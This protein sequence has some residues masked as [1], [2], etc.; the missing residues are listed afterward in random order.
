M[1]NNLEI[2]KIFEL[3]TVQSPV[4]RDISIGL[5]D[6]I[7][8]FEKYHNELLIIYYKDFLSNDLI[9]VFRGKYFKYL[10]LDNNDVILLKNLNK[11]KFDKIRWDENKE[12]FESV[13]HLEIENIIHLEIENIS[14]LPLNE[15]IFQRDNYLYIKL[16]SNCIIIT[17]VDFKIINVVNI[18]DFV[19]I[20]FQN[21]ALVDINHNIYLK[22][23]GGSTTF[24]LKHISN[25]SYDLENPIKIKHNEFI[26]RWYYHPSD[27]F[28]AVKNTYLMFYSNISKISESCNLNDLDKTELSIKIN[29]DYFYPS[30][31]KYSINH[32]GDMIFI[33]SSYGNMEYIM[34]RIDNPFRSMIKSA[35]E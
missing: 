31:S 5:N 18:I 29:D 11:I 24:I 3:K 6:R 16:S 30:T 12:E 8:V 27:F 9:E 32:N 4:K 19:N 33:I 22:Y 23:Q 13:I 10:R 28:V 15:F 21:L 20:R 14:D 7:F 1:D 2:K 34:Y 26:C 25:G 17:D 35:I